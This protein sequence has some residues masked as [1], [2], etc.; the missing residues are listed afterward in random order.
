MKLSAISYQLSADA[1]DV[2]LAAVIPSAARNL[3]LLRNESQNKESEQDSSPS[4]DGDGLPSPVRRR[5]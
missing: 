5:R 3:A 1:K 2:R 4:A